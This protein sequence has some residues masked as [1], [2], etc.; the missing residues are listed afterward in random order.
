MCTSSSRTAFYLQQV[1]LMATSLVGKCAYLFLC[2]FLNIRKKIYRQLEGNRATG[3]Q[4]ACK[5]NNP[6]WHHEQSETGT[7]SAQ[8]KAPA[9]PLYS[10]KVAEE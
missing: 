5:E 7:P 2:R 8:N 3:E 4:V 6:G 10:L 9:L 1:N